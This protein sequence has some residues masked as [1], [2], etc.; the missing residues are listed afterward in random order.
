MIPA[1]FDYVRPTTVAEA[2]AAL[3]DG[4]EDAKLLAGGQSL[5]PVLR[6]RMGDPSLVVDLGGVPELRGVRE[7]GDRH[8]SVKMVVGVRNRL[9]HVEVGAVYHST[10]PHCALERAVKLRSDSRNGV[11]GRAGR[12]YSDAGLLV[13]DPVKC[14][15][16]ALVQEVRTQDITPRS[17]QQA[18]LTRSASCFSRVEVLAAHLRCE[19][20]VTTSSPKLLAGSSAY[21]QARNVWEWRAIHVACQDLRRAKVA[22]S[23]VSIGLGRGPCTGDRVRRGTSGTPSG[24]SLIC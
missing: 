7:E 13:G 16:V 24:D 4:G 18:A 15:Q 20:R 9:F 17:A 8:G 3:V 23:F 6:L 11:V 21:A 1:S 5:I 14:H 12:A 2:V 10:R 19:R 22:M